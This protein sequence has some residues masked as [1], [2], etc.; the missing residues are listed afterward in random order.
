MSGLPK[1][2]TSHEWGHLTNTLCFLQPTLANAE[3][4]SLRNTHERFERD[5]S[6]VDVKT[7]KDFD[8]E[9][10]TAERTQGALMLM[11]IRELI[12]TKRL[13]RVGKK[14]RDT[15]TLCMSNVQKRTCHASATPEEVK[16]NEARTPKWRIR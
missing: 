6:H 9:L 11:D 2:G 13:P 8:H 4:A 12:D 15:D 10:R 5:M 16:A 1:R 3:Q 14:T 7:R